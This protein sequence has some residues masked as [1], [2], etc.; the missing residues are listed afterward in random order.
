MTPEQ[1][2]WIA[3]WEHGAAYDKLPYYQYY[4]KDWYM[5][6][7]MAGRDA[8]AKHGGYKPGSQWW[9]G[10]IRDNACSDAWKKEFY[11]SANLSLAVP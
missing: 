7:F 4:D 3:G 10:W 2:S 11:S 8:A 1:N 6:G 5:K 9:I